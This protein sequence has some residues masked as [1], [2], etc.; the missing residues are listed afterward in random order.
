[1]ADLWGG[2]RKSLQNEN[3]I[4]ERT[5]TIPESPPGIQR[6]KL[7]EHSNLSL[8]VDGQNEEDSQCV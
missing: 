4:K 5:L 6:A 7:N 8:A 2:G 3:W 1:M